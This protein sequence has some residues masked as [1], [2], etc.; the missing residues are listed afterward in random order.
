MVFGARGGEL[1]NTRPPRVAPSR[2]S[3][4]GAI[5]ILVALAVCGC[6]IAPIYTAPQPENNSALKFDTPGMS[7][8]Y[9]HLNGKN[10]TENV[11]PSDQDNPFRNSTKELIVPSNKTVAVTLAWGGLSAP[12]LVWNCTIKLSFKL[13]PNERYRLVGRQSGDSCTAVIVNASS[14]LTTEAA[15]DIELKRM[16]QVTTAASLAF[17]ISAAT[18]EPDS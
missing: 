7:L 9:F 6:A 8:F 3:K 13:K 16:R 11:R 2:R 1:K 12:N 14:T 15:N 4:V 17:G 10:C 5:S 18:C